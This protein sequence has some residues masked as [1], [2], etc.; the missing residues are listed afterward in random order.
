M[1]RFWISVCFT[2]M[3]FALTAMLLGAC[4]PV[5][6]ATPSVAPTAEAE[7]ERV[8][9]A[10]GNAGDLLPAALPPS[11]L[12]RS[13][14]RTDFDRR[15]V[16]WD[17]IRSGG[18]PKDGIPAIDTPTF[19]SVADAATWLSDRDPILVFAYNGEV[20]GY[21]LAILIWHEIVNDRVGELPVTIT[22]CPLCNASIVFGRE[23]EGQILDFGTTGLLRM[24]D[25]IMY[26][27][28]SES[29]WQQAT[30]RAIVGQHAG[31]ELTFY[32]TQILSFADFSAAYA[33]SQLLA[34]PPLSRSYGA[35]PYVG[36]DSQPGRPFLYDGELDERLDAT[37]R[38]VGLQIGE[39]IMAYPFALLQ[40]QKVVNDTV[41]DVP[42]VI[43]HKE[44][45]A[46]ALDASQIA[47]GRDVGSSV[48]FERQVG[49]RVLTFAPLEDGNFRDLET[50]SVWNFL[51]Q[52]ITG[53]LAGEQLSQRV[54]FDHFW[55]AWSAFFPQ[56]EVYTE[57]P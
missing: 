33:E 28:Q 46:S 22:F 56:T 44:G 8:E 18:P 27:R 39:A 54:A 10:G 32:A 30:G 29:W 47:E 13:E 37:A 17:E 20:R 43:L 2:V 5:T 4:A 38:V 49:D 36:Y 7:T 15:T 16:E 52:A 34:R 35:N 53:E 57:E 50:D 12:L 24:S 9:P 42:V 19:E 26:D 55:F 45:V 21:P 25:L 14:W 48:V 23:F 1:P 6:P 51:G 41:G 3:T 31:K 40:A 11:D